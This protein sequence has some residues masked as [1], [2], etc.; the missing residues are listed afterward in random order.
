MLQFLLLGEVEDLLPNGKL[1]VDL[2]GRQPNVGDVEEP[3]LLDCFVQLG[4]QLCLPARCVELRQ[5]QS[6]KICPIHYILSEL[7]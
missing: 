4:S 7:R 6:D 1:S 2:L 5:I 3:D